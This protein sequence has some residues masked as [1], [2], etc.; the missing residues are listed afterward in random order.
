MH[1]EARRYVRVAF[2]GAVIYER[3]DENSTRLAYLNKGTVLEVIDEE[4][5]FLRVRTEDGAEAYIRKS[6]VASGAA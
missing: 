1:G 4:E 5:G 2:L 3:P 6:S